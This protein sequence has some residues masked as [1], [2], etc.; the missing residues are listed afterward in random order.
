MEATRIAQEIP[1]AWTLATPEQRKRM[2]WSVFNRSRIS[3]AAIASVRPEPET[4]ALLAAAVQRG[5]PDRGLTRN[6]E[7]RIRGVSVEQIEDLLA[8]A[9]SV[10]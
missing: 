1:R 9:R 4:V 5:G 6:G 10:A 2:V 8:L 3:R 7:V